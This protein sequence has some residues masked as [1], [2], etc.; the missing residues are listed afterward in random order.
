MARPLSNSS[1]PRSKRN[2]GVIHGL[3][4]KA[5]VSY[6]RSP[7]ASASVVYPSPSA[8]RLET[9]PCLC[10]K[11]PVISEATDG[12][13]QAACAVARSKTTAS[14]AS[15]SK[16][17]LLGMTESLLREELAHG[18]RATAICPG[19]VATSMVTE[20]RAP[21]DEMIQPEDIADAMRCVALMPKRTSLPEIVV[22]PTNIRPYTPAESGIPS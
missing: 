2:S 12:F 3:P 20:S 14:P 6:P 21:R 18:I 9:T 22:Y 4:E 11:T 8:S 5:A 7:S 19:L 10:T 1:K 13:V 17:G 16:F 15:A